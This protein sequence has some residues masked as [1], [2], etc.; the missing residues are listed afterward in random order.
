MSE[1]TQPTSKTSKTVYLERP[2]LEGLQK[3]LAEARDGGVPGHAE[4]ALHI[5]REGSTLSYIAE[6]V[7]AETRSHIVFSWA[8]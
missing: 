7:G 6:A 8:D 5:I 1:K 4:P 3:A 2:S